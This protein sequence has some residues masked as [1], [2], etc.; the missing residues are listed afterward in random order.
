MY[1]PTPALRPDASIMM[2]L[3][4]I[5]KHPKTQSSQGRRGK[6]KRAGPREWP[7]Q[8]QPQHGAAASRGDR[9][10]PSP[11]WSSGRISSPRRGQGFKQEQG[12]S[13]VRAR[14][15]Q[16]PELARPQDP[17]PPAPHSGAGAMAPPGGRALGPTAGDPKFPCLIGTAAEKRTN[18]A[19]RSDSHR[20]WGCTAS[21]A[22][23]APC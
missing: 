16:N 18:G 12:W 17:H 22:L 10:V 23:P 4:I 5:R 20:R 9:T 13:K 1:T 14:L 19:S 15:P 3:H 21:P 8:P 2:L 11:V 6:V 7:G